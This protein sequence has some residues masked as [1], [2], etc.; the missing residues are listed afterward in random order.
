MM[1][2]LALQFRF[3]ATLNEIDEDYLKM[4]CSYIA[5]AAVPSNHTPAHITKTGG[6]SPS[7]FQ[8]TIA[9]YF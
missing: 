1:E 9:A 5:G 3:P 8:G 7:K 2:P 4:K 6:T